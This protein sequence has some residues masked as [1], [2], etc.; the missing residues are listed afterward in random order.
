MKRPGSGVAAAAI[1]VLLVLAGCGGKTDAAVDGGGDVNDLDGRTF[2]ST[3][4]TPKDLVP[5]SQIRLWFD[6]GS[7][8][9]QAGCNSMGARV[10]VDGGRLVVTEPMFMTEMGCS[11]PLMAQDEWLAEVL[12]SGPEL[13]SDGDTLTLRAADGTVIELTDREVADPDRPLT[14]TTWRLDG[15]IQGTGGDGTVSSV[16]DGVKSTLRITNDGQVGVNTGCNSAAGRVEV[17]DEVLRFGQVGMTLM[18]CTG[19]RMRVERAVLAVV[20][21]GEVSYTIEASTLTLTSGDHGLMY[22]AD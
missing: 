21:N 10:R 5:G 13:T 15:I 16:P 9:A 11:E 22:R 2:L 7:L 6:D 18:E 8:T 17:S 14:G 3:S 20:H 19:D 4:V 12:G 1:G